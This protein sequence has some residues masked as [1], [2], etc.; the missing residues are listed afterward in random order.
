MIK[1][2]AD[3]ISLDEEDDIIILGFQE[4][5]SSKYLFVSQNMEE[6]EN[7]GKTCYLEINSQS[8]GGY[9]LIQEVIF[10]LK[11]IHIQ[12]NKKG[13]DALKSNNIEIKINTES[14]NSEYLKLILLRIFKNRIR[15]KKKN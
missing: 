9:G 2:K 6:I 3:N 13:I 15:I 7:E 1:L 5:K 12:L 11:E 14:F 8:K 10:E 4:K